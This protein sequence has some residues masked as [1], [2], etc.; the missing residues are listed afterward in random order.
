MPMNVCPFSTPVHTGS[1]PT[2]LTYTQC[3]PRLISSRLG[4]QMLLA[5]L[6][7]GLL[8]LLGSLMHTPAL[9]AVPAP[10]EP[11]PAPQ[12]IL[13]G[14]Y[15]FAEMTAGASASY[16]VELPQAGTYLLAPVEETGAAIFDLRTTDATGTQAYS[17]PLAS[18]ELA[19]EAGPLSLEF[20]ANQD[21]LLAF[22]VLGPMGALSPDPA[23][24]GILAAGSF[25]AERDPDGPR[26]GTLVIPATDYPQQVLLY[27][28]VD[29]EAGWQLTVDGGAL[30]MFQLNTAQENLLRF[31]SQG[32][33]YPL[34]LT[35]DDSP[36]SR[37]LVVPF[38]GGPPPAVPLDTPLAAEIRAGTAEAFYQ[39]SLGSIYT[40]LT[41]TVDAA[42][43][44][45]NLTL[46]DRLMGGVVSADAGGSGQ[47][48]LTDLLPGTY[49][50]WVQAPT[51]A[52]SS[53]PFTLTVTGVAG[54]PI[55]RLENQVA[56]PGEFAEG[57]EQHTYWLSV[58]QAGSLIT[59]SLQ[60]ENPD[61]NYTVQVALQPG[62][63][64]WRGEG[65]TPLRFVAPRPGTYLVDVLSNGAPGPYSLLAQVA[66]PVMALDPAAPTWDQIAPGE[67]AFYR[68]AV[69]GP[70]QI[71]TVIL[72]GNPA[73]E[74]DLT[75][76]WVDPETGQ[77][78]TASSAGGGS[79]EV[80]S[81]SR[82]VPGL[83]Q[84]AVQAGAV[85]GP[86]L[87]MVRLEDPSLLGG[88]WA[89]EATASSQYGETDYSAAQAT[90]TPDTPLP[91]DFPTAWAPENPDDGLQTLELRYAHLVVPT[92]IRIYETY[93]P[94]AVVAVE[95]YNGEADEWVVL[96]SGQDPSQEA[97]AV[98]SPPLNP[99][100]FATDRLRLTLDTAAVPG[101]NEVDAV[102]LVGRP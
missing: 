79:V 90:G 31:W 93:N 50:L 49:Y 46:L 61:V 92:A 21:G 83:Y 62:A 41:A 39:I 54:D 94:G 19:T 4:R 10:Q 68:L 82:T 63:P 9:W 1:E 84:V 58:P 98:F 69:D 7:A 65:G 29:E 17:G 78:Q 66:D 70:D 56:A 25:Y 57:E 33:E 64:L 72:V 5:W 27:I 18:V 14:Q 86:Y 87:L 42:D 80:V 22:V 96:W 85:G 102:Q 32:G 74:L 47:L 71:L 15:V 88:Q 43:D 16:V 28:G 26:Y 40:V 11:P 55:P 24:P 89:V 20:T 53:Q 101:W 45:W 97:P 73:A 91:G 8:F 30:G 13:L 51:G 59:L 81:Q 100:D 36:G 60:A 75:V 95:A 52:E 2:A 3:S 76:T 99:A 35:P 38:L 12:A 37:L 34:A 23:Q 44:G 48:T 67:T 77:L 6:A